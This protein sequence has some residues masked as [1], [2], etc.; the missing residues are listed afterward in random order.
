[1]AGLD[2]ALPESPD[3]FSAG[4]YANEARVA[5]R[6]AYSVVPMTGADET[7]ILIRSE[8]L[9][10]KCFGLRAEIDG[11]QGASQNPTLKQLLRQQ[12][13]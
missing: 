7:R 13:V 12:N 4:N 1:M 10:A 3:V 6:S 8:R 11:V 2:T 9:A 5:A